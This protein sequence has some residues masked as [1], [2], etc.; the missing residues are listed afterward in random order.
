MRWCAVRENAGEDHWE[1]QERPAEAVLQNSGWHEARLVYDDTWMR[2]GA[3]GVGVV[4]FHG[5][6]VDTLGVFVGS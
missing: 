1:T 6:Y 2:I 5:R 4:M 3:A